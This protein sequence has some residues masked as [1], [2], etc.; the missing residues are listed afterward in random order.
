MYDRSY[1]NV[2]KFEDFVGNKGVINKVKLLIHEAKGDTAARAPD[3]AFIGP[4][5][6]GKTTLART[7]AD[8]LGRH[9]IE[10]NAT[11]VRDP[12]QFRSYIINPAMPKQGA[13]VLI[14]ECHQLKRKIQ[15]NLLSATE[16]PRKLHTSHRDEIFVDSIPENFSFIFA[17]TRA[18]Y[19][20]NEL[21]SRLEVI[22]FLEYSEEELC[23]MV[24][25]YMLRQHEISLGKDDIPILID[26]AKRSRS[27]RHVV[28]NCNNIVRLM[29]KKQIN[30]LSKELL[31]EAFD[32]IGI[33][34]NGLT[35]LDRKLLSYLSK[36]NTFVGL[37]TLEALMNMPKKDIRENLEP[38]LLRKNYIVRRSSGRVITKKGIKAIG[39][40]DGQRRISKK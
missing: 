2:L 20:R 26:I 11:V 32:I 37:D 39:V 35:R 25:K 31:K 17:T 33:D 13:I 7:I 5:G 38:F 4:A 40:S 24:I 36:R 18:G 12:F 27:G 1:M 15:D 16:S 22:E 34:E 9:Y 21:L 29:K 19:I 30:K 3:M 28:K 23:E 6:H 14:D 8:D 10:I